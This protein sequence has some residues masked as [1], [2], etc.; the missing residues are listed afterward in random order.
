[1]NHFTVLN[2]CLAE[3]CMNLIATVT[4]WK[5]LFKLQI[6]LDDTYAI[7]V[8]HVRRLSIKHLKPN[9]IIE[10][11]S[12]CLLRLTILNFP[13]NHIASFRKVDRQFVCT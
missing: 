2:Y 11:S 3:Y 7:S 6:N 12:G 8:F 5:E 4:A 9:Y 13:E 10:Q 1:M